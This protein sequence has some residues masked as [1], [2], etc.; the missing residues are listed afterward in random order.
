MDYKEQFAELIKDNKIEDAR[1]LLEQYSKFA[2]DDPFY[3]ANMGWIYNHMERF[4]EAEIL[5]RKGLALF[6]DEAWMYSQ[7]GF[8]LNRQGDIEQGLDY[9]KKALAEGFDEPWLH[10]E[11]GW[12]YKEKKEYKTAIEY[13]ENGLL[14]DPDNLWILSQAAYTYLDLND[15]ATAEEYFL[16]AFRIHHDP[17]TVGDLVWF[18]KTQG[19]YE[20]AIS[21]L[22]TIP[23]GVVDQWRE[24]ELGF[25]YNQL[26][27]YELAL[28]HLKKTLELGRDDTNVRSQLGDCYQRCGQVDK[29]NES[30]NLAL[31]YYEKALTKEEEH[32]WI[33]QEMIWIAHKQRDFKK[34][35]S[36]LDRASAER[37]DDLWLMYHYA[38]VYSDLNE[39]EKAIDAC[40]FCMEHGE[41]SKEMYDLYAWNLG[42]ALKSEEAIALLKQRMDT[43]GSEDWVYGELGWNYAELRD[44]DTAIEYFTKALESNPQNP[45]H[46]SMMAWCLLQKDD[47]AHAL[48]YVNQAKEQGRDD[49]WIHAV[50]GEIQTGLHNHEEAIKEYEEALARDFKES[51]VQKELDKLH[52]LQESEQANKVEGS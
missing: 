34:K 24:Y 35:L 39:Y 41:T 36:Y 37:K 40:K 18:Y 33:Y 51:W 32:Y 1:I 48:T 25:C 12:C 26:D 7:L 8:S 19:K 13:F 23:D 46:L 44:I 38:R 28:P 22:K 27:Q 47:F 3:Y 43:Y 6:P 20:K 11:I 21:Y 16:K 52:K 2:S 15:T 17:E 45:L 31:E 42:R 4:Q 50:S 14:D 9:L 29:A 49:G 5:L 30:Y 10:G